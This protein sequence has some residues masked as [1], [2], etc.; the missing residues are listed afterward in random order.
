MRLVILTYILFVFLPFDLE[1]R[2]MD[3]EVIYFTEE[4]IDAEVAYALPL[5]SIASNEPISANQNLKDYHSFSPY[6]WVDTSLSSGTTLIYKDGQ[7]NAIT[8]AMSDKVIIRQ[9]SSA[10]YSLYKGYKKSKNLKYANRA[11]EQIIH[12]FLD[13][14]FGMNPHLEFAQCIPGG[15]QGNYWGLIDSRWLVLVVESIE[16]FELH[17]IFTKKQINAIRNWFMR[18]SDWMIESSLGQEAAISANNHASWYYAQLATYKWFVKE[19]KIANFIVNNSKRLFFTQI[20]SIGQQLMEIGRTKSFDYSLYNLAA[21]V[22]LSK[23]GDSV[24]IDLWKF[25]LQNGKNL[26][27]GIKF[28]SD[29]VSNGTWPYK[30]I[31]PKSIKLCYGDG[32]TFSVYYPYDLNY[33]VEKSENR[34]QSNLFYDIKHYLSKCGDC[35]S[36]NY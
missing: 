19:K 32:F 12:F 27:N 30:Q 7:T 11:K 5:F 6:V 13:K 28:L 20:D 17:D 25:N 31:A 21:L 24:G 22:Q 8:E 23:I 16:Y 18:Y 34:I 35:N 29:H 1:A 15:V 4:L 36:C 33:L 2:S 10:V 3:N 14:K 9:F 26:S